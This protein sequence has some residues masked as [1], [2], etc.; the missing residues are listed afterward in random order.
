VIIN[1]ST[2]EGMYRRA[3]AGMS[4]LFAVR[5]ALQAE[6][7]TP[8]V[9]VLSRRHTK[10]PDPILVVRMVNPPFL[11][12]VPSGRERDKAREVAQFARDRLKSP[13]SYGAFE[14]TF[15]R[16]VSFGGTASVNQVFRFRP[17]ELG[18]RDGR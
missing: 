13:D 7:K 17:D 12:L 6:Y 8:Q 2:L 4:E 14:V 9:A 15:T 11:S 1:W 18:P 10:E 3:A 5:A 16:Q